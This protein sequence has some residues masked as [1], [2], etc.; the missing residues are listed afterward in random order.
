METNMARFAPPALALLVGALSL[1]CTVS[2]AEAAPRKADLYRTWEV[3]GSDDQGSYTGTMVFSDGGSM[4]IA[5]DAQLTYADGTQRSWSSSGY[6]VFGALYC[7]YTVASGLTGALSGNAG[8]EVRGTLRPDAR[9][10]SI[11]ATYRI[12]G[13]T[14]S[15]Q[16]TLYRAGR[17]GYGYRWS[18]RVLDSVLADHPTLT[19]DAL[20]LEGA[21]HDGGNDYLSRTE[22]EA[23]AAALEATPTP[24]PA[25][26]PP[27][28]GIISDIDKTVLPP[29]NDGD[30]LPDPYPGVT[31]LYKE[32]LAGSTAM[33]YV[34]ART[35]DMVGTEVPDWMASVGLPTAPIETGTPNFWDAQNEKVRDIE[36]TLADHPGVKFVFF[37]DSSHRDPEVYRE[38][39]TK[40]PD[41]VHAVFIH[42]VNNVNPNRVAGMNLI[43]DY[44]QVV[45][46]LHELGFL[47]DAAARRVL[48]A[49]QQEGLA[50]TDAEIDALLQ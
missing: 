32:L 33:R 15:G 43:T 7:R 39:Q 25:P 6:Y 13:S 30:P 2:E 38:I 49:A 18:D 19:E 22:L 31:D 11:A 8:A 28:V 16:E 42:K 46:K 45:D 3:E 40:Y 12:D 9:A 41:R 4:K 20:L 34:T 23:A 14:F 48:E 10:T 29:H 44:S 35:A 36:K 47:T 1:T 17:A 5:V 37:G 27:A 21:K 26:T 50:I 24:P